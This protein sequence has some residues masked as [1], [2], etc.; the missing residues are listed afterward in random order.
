MRPRSAWRPI[1]WLAAA[2]LVLVAAG[3]APLAW[4]GILALRDITAAGATLVSS[5]TAR[6]LVNTL[7]LGVLVAVAVGA[8]G[9]ALGLLVAKTDL[10][11]GRTLRALLTFPLFLPPYVLALGWFTILGR[12]GL[13]MALLGPSAGSATSDAF[14]GVSGS[15]LVLTVAYTPIVLHV[16]RLGLRSIDPATEEAARLRF[17]WSRV[18]WRIDLPLIAPAI[19]L[20]MLLTFILV[21]GEFGVPA[22]LRYPVFSGAV[23]TQFAA[24]LDIR[25]AVITSIPLGLLVLAGLVAERYWLRAR[26][27]FLECVRPLSVVA[28]L[29]AWRIAAATGAWAYALVTVVLPL[30]GLV[31]QA[32]GGVNYVTALRG[33]GSSIATSLWTAAVAATVMVSVGLLLAYLVERT[34]RERRNIVD[35]ALVLLF[36]VPGTVLGVA[37]ILLWNRRGL[38]PVYA[39]IGIILIGYVAHYTPLAPRAIGVSL[40]AVSARVEEAARVAGVPWTRMMRRVLL[41]ALAPAVGGAWALT[42]LFCLRDLDLVMTVHPPGVETLPVRLYTLMANSASSVTAALSCIMVILTIGCVLVTGA[43]L[44]VVRRITAWS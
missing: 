17:S 19:A 16:V 41:P 11:G 35:T 37:L 10:T 2:L 33:A 12:Q 9:T 1:P 22:Y 18:V 32:G 26:V 38:T 27:H 44:G 8:V 24:F 42:F 13:I 28:P 30:G 29:G 36:A 20:G 43:A 4:L 14:F 25:A 6:L 39:S 21:I 3:G 7:R 40:Q 31:L 34:A 15:V 5:G 23:F